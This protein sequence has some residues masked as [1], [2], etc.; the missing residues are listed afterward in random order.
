MRMVKIITMACFNKK[1]TIVFIKNKAILIIS[2]IFYIL[3]SKNTFFCYS[4]NFTYVLLILLLPAWLLFIMIPV[5]IDG[6]NVASYFK[7]AK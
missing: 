4:K 3:F 7:A 1:M 2:Y 5:S 6:W